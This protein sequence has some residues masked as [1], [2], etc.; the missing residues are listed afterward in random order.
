MI[1]MSKKGFTDLVSTSWT[2]EREKREFVF[3]G[4]EKGYTGFLRFRVSKEGE[5]EK[6]T[7]KLF[8]K[9]T[10]EKQQRV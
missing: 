9:Q 5:R 3:K 1:R 10:D 8:T 2:R 4:E 7:H 6:H